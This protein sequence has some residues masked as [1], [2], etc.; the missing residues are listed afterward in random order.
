VLAVHNGQPRSEHGPIK[1][2]LVTGQ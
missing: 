2:V 1:S